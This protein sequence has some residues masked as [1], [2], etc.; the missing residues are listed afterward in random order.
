MQPA[1]TVASSALSP[2]ELDLRVRDYLPK[3]QRLAL[4][5]AGNN[6][7]AEDVV[8]DALL[9][10]ARKWRSFDGR[11]SLETWMH[12]IVVNAFRDRLRSQKRQRRL[13][14]EVADQKRSE[15]HADEPDSELSAKVA[16]CIAELPRRQ[17]EVA[18]LVLMEE[19]APSDAAA[20]LDLTPQNI[21]VHLYHARQKL[22]EML[23]DYLE[24]ATAH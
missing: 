7:D 4:R 15:Q 2:D 9:N 8:A 23:A 22:Q 3:A 6:A 13:L 10:I 14:R 11:A 1:P 17:R 16:A 21:R 24:P 12:R 20:V 18:V 19:L 5:L